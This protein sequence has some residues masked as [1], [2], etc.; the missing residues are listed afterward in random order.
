M[1]VRDQK[2]KKNIQ[3][4]PRRLNSQPQQSRDGNIGRADRDLLDKIFAARIFR[5][6]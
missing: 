2:K 5:C 1:Q 4:P 6:C 3:L